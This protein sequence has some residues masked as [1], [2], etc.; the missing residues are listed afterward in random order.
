LKYQLKLQEI[1]MN[2]TQSVAAPA[3]GR[4]FV[5]V[6]AEDFQTAGAAVWWELDGEVPHQVLEGLGEGLGLDPSKLPSKPSAEVALRRAMQTAG[7]RRRMMVRPLTK[8]GAWA[9]VD[10][11]RQGEDL[12][13]NVEL[14]ARLEDGQLRL[15]PDDHPR[16]AAVAATFDRAQRWLTASDISEWL[17]ATARRLKA[18]PLRDRG[19]MYFIPQAQLAEWEQVRRALAAVSDHTLYQMA[20][21]PTAEVI[22]AVLDGV[23]REAQAQIAEM[24]RELNEGEMGKRALASKAKACTGAAEKV[25]YYEG[26]LGRALPALHERLEG[27]QA[28]LAA[29]ALAN[30]ANG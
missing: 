18:V 8:R 29:A 6:R 28:R 13:Y 23:E 26:L 1:R 7:D 14:R 19:G 5:V 15:T 22:Q 17:I 24:D 3:G 27:L 9:L 11:T 21:L 20:A 25:R 10:E 30:Q 16:A 4:S 2:G 12:T